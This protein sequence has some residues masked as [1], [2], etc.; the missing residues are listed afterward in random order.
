MK[1]L[2]PILIACLILINAAGL[3]L[4]F[5]DKQKA[6]RKAWRI[7]ESTLLTVAA[8]GGSIGNLFGMYLFRHKTRH[9]KFTLGIPVIL[10][11]QIILAYFLTR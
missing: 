6:R 7:P 3:V 11:L 10:I 8:L 1:N 9:L 2:L 4:M 5:I